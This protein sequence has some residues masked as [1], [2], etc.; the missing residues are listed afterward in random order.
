MSAIIFENPPAAPKANSLIRTEAFWDRFTSAELVDYDVAMQHDP[1]SSNAAKKDAA[2]LRIFK[3]DAG[4]S[5][6]RKM[7][8]NKVT[9]FVTGLETSGILA[10]GRATMILTAPVTQDEAFT[11]V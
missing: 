1:A 8:S 3:E 11:R 7:S 5:G 2:K 10:A 6:Y 9:S 4:F